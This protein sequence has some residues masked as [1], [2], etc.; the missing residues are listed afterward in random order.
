MKFTHDIDVFLFRDVVA[1][2]PYD[3]DTNQ[4][5]FWL[6]VSERLNKEFDVN[7][8]ERNCR[9]RVNLKVRDFKKEERESRKG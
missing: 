2:N 3:P 7:S 1:T 8:T 4:K 9:E 6:D 5:Q